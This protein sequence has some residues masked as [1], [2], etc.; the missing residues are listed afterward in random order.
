MLIEVDECIFDDEQFKLSHGFENLD[1][2]GKEAFVNHIH[3]DEGEYEKEAQAKI[4]EWTREMI[5]NWPN[6]LFKIYRHKQDDEVT[7]RF[8]LVRE[9]EVDWCESCAEIEIIEVRT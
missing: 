9:N 5:E 8:H 3:F 2:V 6:R 1:G 4:D 7:V